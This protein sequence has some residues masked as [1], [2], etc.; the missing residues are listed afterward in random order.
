MK[1]CTPLGYFNLPKLLL[2]RGSTFL[3]LECAFSHH[4]YQPKIM[5]LFIRLFTR[6]IIYFSESKSLKAH[7]IE[8]CPPMRTPPSLGT[9]FS[10]EFVRKY[11]V[12]IKKS[13]HLLW[14]SFRLDKSQ[15]MPIKFFVDQSSHSFITC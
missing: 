5:V 9:I 8:Y 2:S 6:I 7:L 3:V 10:I 12:W 11:P 13:W 14:Y 4:P 1:E 15:S